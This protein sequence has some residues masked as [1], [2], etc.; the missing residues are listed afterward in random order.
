MTDNIKPAFAETGFSCSMDGYTGLVS[1]S[2]DALIFIIP[3]A[4]TVL[5]TVLPTDLGFALNHVYKGLKGAGTWPGYLMAAG[6][7]LALD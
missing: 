7:Y 3:I 2:I 6:Y 5:G 4:I 1:D